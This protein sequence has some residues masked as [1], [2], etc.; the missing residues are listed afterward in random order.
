MAVGYRGG[1]ITGKIGGDVG[2]MVKNAKGRTSQGWRAYQPKVTNP[3]K[4]AQRYNRV[5]LST[6]A[7]AYSVLRPICDHAFEG[8]SGPSR[9]QKEFAKLNV[10]MLQQE[11]PLGN[12]NWNPRSEFSMMT[13][14]YIVS[15][16]SLARLTYDYGSAQNLIRLYLPSSI[17]N[18]T[19]TIGEFFDAMGWTDGGQITLMVTY[20]DDTPAVSEFRFARLVFKLGEPYNGGTGPLTRETTLFTTVGTVPDT[21]YNLAYNVVESVNVGLFTGSPNFEAEYL[22]GWNIKMDND[23]FGAEPVNGFA[24]INSCLVGNVWKRSTQAF[25]GMH[26]DSADYSMDLAIS[27]YDSTQNSSLYLNHG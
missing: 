16:G 8:I 25:F 6:M 10:R 3:N 4:Y 1:L 24:F 13:N 7:K 9:N 22:L 18:D 20:G 26:P 21:E 2:Y 5:I 11:A 12:G 14:P 19:P 17:G 27:S 15:K 23:A